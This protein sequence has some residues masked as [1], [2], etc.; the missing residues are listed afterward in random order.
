MW[1]MSTLTIAVCVT[2]FCCAPQG[3][4]STADVGSLEG[5]DRPDLC[6]GIPAQGCCAGTTLIWCEAGQIQEVNCASKPACGWNGQVGS[7]DCGTDGGEDPAGVFLI[8]CQE[9]ESE[10]SDASE[11]QDAAVSLDTMSPDAELDLDIGAFEEDSDA[12]EDTGAI[13]DLE[14]ETVPED[15]VVDPGE[16]A[17][18]PCDGVECDMGFSCVEGECVAGDPCEGVE[19]DEG[20]SCVEGEC[21]EDVVVDPCEGVECAEGST[22]VWGV[23][24]EP[25]DACINEAD[26]AVLQGDPEVGAKIKTCAMNCLADA[27]PG[28]C[29]TDC[30]V[31]DTGLS[32]GCAG[33]YAGTFMCSVSNCLTQCM[34][35]PDPEPCVICQAEFCAA[36]F[37][38]CT[39]IPLGGGE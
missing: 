15:D 3:A 5:V 6:R 33:C 20:F 1:R 2:T 12:V 8:S 32:G 17:T 36:D 26:L 19:C 28:T 10:D 4:Q 7:Y 25:G 34:A 24:G 35:D 31:A 37:L 39:G 22:C 16:T 27:D 23:C 13:S 11:G 18:D 38:A 30:I 14:E 21:V 29:A 9:A